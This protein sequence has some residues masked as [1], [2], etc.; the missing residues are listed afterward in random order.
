[1]VFAESDDTNVSDDEELIQGDF[2][3]VKLVSAKSRIAHYIARIDEM[4]E[5]EFEGVFLK[6]ESSLGQNT[7]VF[8]INENDEAS[9]SKE[10]VVMKLPVPCQVGRTAHT[11]KKF[12]FSCDFS[13]CDFFHHFIKHTEHD[14]NQRSA[15]F[16]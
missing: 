1:M 14:L 15:I 4:D 13:N 8:V 5:N 12:T 9:F 10:D 6:R 16:S 2:V 11:A 7:F 3:I